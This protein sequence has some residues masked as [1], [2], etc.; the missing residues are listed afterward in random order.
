MK[1]IPFGLV[2][3]VGTADAP[4]LRATLRRFL[5]DLEFEWGMTFVCRKSLSQFWVGFL[6]GAPVACPARRFSSW[7]ERQSLFQF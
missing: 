7:V 6:G 4:S 3:I 2:V 5:Q 1:M